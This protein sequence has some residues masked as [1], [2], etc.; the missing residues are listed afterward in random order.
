MWLMKQCLERPEIKRSLTK[1]GT[2]WKELD[3]KVGDQLKGDHQ[4]HSKKEVLLL[5][6]P[7][8]KMA[9]T[10]AL[11]KKK[12]FVGPEELLITCYNYK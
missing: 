12:N 8:I 4:R 9:A 5:L 6:E 11:N 3:K 10:T 1:A 2:S 7:L